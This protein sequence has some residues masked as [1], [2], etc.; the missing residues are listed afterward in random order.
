MKKPSSK[1]REEIAR[2]QDQLKQAETREAE[3]IGRIALKAG[4]GDI[5]IDEAELQAAF[6]DV[7]K[8]FRGGKGS[9]TGKRQAGD[10]RTGSEP[11][12]TQPTGADA[13]GLSEA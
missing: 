9:A 1:I 13:G 12:A 10:S 5:E 7:A 6:E 3:R 2:L 11:Y 8:R 4:L